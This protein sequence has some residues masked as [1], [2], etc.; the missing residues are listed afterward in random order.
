MGL[1]ESAFSTAKRGPEYPGQFLDDSQ[2]GIYFEGYFEWY[3]D[4]HYHF[5]I[6]YVTPQQAHTGLRGKIVH[7]A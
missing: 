7:R 6:A 5:A 4:E 3:N 1:I 2:A